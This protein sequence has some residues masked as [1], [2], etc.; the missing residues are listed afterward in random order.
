MRLLLLPL[1]HLRRA[2]E[3]PAKPATGVVSRAFTTQNVYHYS[4]PVD[5][6]VFCNVEIDGLYEKLSEFELLARSVQRGSLSDPQVLNKVVSFCARFSC[7]DVGIQIH[8]VIV[9]MG[10][11]SNVFICSALVDMYGKC[12]KLGNARKVFDDMPQR[13]VVTWNSLISGCLLDECPKMAIGLFVKMLKEGIAPTEFS[14]SGVLVGCSQLEEEEFGIQVHGLSL[15]L[16]FCWN[17][18]V[19][20][21]LVDVYSRCSRIDDSRQVFD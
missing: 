9:K 12:R 18:V 21:G 1:N 17:V 2:L 20:T 8:T 3:I 4:D 19:G 13:N 16:G 14:L 15:K 11:C 10:F 6:L 7:L 5:D